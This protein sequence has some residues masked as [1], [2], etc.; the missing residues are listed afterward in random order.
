LTLAATRA[1]PHE[2][3][4]EH[5]DGRVEVAELPNGSRRVQAF[6]SDPA[7]FS[8]QT[9]CVTTYPLE[10]IRAILEVKG[11]AWLCYSLAR[12]R[13][14]DGIERVLRHSLFDF[15]EP[16]EFRN[17]RLLDFGCGSGASTIVLD[18]LV[19]GLQVV[20]VDILDE[21]LKIARLRAAHVG[22]DAEFVRS[23]GGAELPPDLGEFDAVCLSAVVEHMLPSERGVMLR[24]VW[25]VL[26][27]GGIL[28][29]NQTP[30]R[31]YPIEG[32]T[33]DLPLLNYVSDRA[34]L[35]LARRFS[36]RLSGDET[37]EE[38]LRA[39]IRG[40]TGDEI[41][42]A[43]RSVGNGV[44]VR[45]RPRQPG[46]RDEID[47]WYAYSTEHRTSTSKRV[48]YRAFKAVSRVTGDSFAPDIVLAIRKD[49]AS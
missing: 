2:T 46:M 11:P 27:P 36:R 4:L 29:V 17:K 39:G 21:M 6:V 35:R 16:E 7:T 12:D 47:V 30:H 18:R 5:P 38:L 9:V 22:V 49:V 44:P 37:W 10:L 20:G 26:R 3:L 24:S 32:H 43:L 31:Y 25:S 48:A 1:D 40:A 23:P 41:M 14:P 42:R 15:V 19:P 13:D 33:T 34:A 8:P 28:F 45:L